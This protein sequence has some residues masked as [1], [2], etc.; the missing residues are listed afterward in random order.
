MT[1]LLVL[2]AAAALA[3]TGTA[4]A[5]QPVACAGTVSI[6]P[7]PASFEVREAGGNTFVSFA[8]TGTHDFCLADGSVVTGT[9]AGELTQRTGA[10]GSLSIR[11]SETFAYGDGTLAYRGEASLNG[12]GWQ[13]NV[14]TVG[15][16][17]GSLAGIHG[18][19]AFF[20]TATPGL[21]TDVIYYHYH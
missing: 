17:T 9:V 18:H 15:S 4:V 3:L 6:A 8:F 12:S 20:P 1:R 16:G 14:Q 13:S 21:F 7:D 19:G 2:A 5:G 11:F 10:D